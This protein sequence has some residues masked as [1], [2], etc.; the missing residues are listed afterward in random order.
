MSFV[1]FEN[2]KVIKDSSAE[3][4]PN[5]YETIQEDFGRNASEDREG[6]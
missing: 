3:D 4:N 5:Y 6:N 2:E 1:L